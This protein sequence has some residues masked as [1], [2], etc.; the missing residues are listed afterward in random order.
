ML[1]K[2][3]KY[4]WK[5]IWKIPTLLLLILWGGAFISSLPFAGPLFES[6]GEI[7]LILAAILWGIFIVASIGVSFGITIYVALQFYYSMYSD[8]GYLTHTLPVTPRQLLIA[9]GL[10]MTVWDILCALGVVISY[11]IFGGMAVLL[12]DL[13]WARIWPQIVEVISSVFS[14]GGEILE[15]A[16]GSWSGLLAVGVIGSLV[17]LLLGTAHVMGAITLGQLAKKHKIGVA[18]AAGCIIAAVLSLL[19]GAL[20]IP[21][22]IGGYM[23]WDMYNMMMT[24]AWLSILFYAVVTVGLFIISENIIR[25]KLNLE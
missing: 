3:I 1:G 17:S 14:S 9:K 18:I 8:E 23:E 10:V 25:K 19:E 11:L 4:E 7:M 2:L 22:M 24:T 16:G 15:A 21:V 6:N 12:T 5:R 13:E 20:Q